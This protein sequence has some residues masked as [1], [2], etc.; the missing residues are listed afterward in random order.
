VRIAHVERKSNQF[1]HNIISRLIEGNITTKDLEVGNVES[2]CGKCYLGDAFRCAS[3]PYLGQPAF[4][5]GDRVKLKNAGNTQANVESEKINVKTTGTKV[6][7]E[8]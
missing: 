1:I 5:K 8:L 4:E 3:C 7:L 6:M 2:S